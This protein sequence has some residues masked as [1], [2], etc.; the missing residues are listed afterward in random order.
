[1]KNIAIFILMSFVL[2]EQKTFVAC[3]GNFYQGNGSLWALS[4]GEAY[5][6]V[7]DNCKYIPTTIDCSHI[8]YICF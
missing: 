3:E 5:E 7:A 1:M 8:E 4:D 2:C 6:Y